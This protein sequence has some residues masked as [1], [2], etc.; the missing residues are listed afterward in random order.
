[1]EAWKSAG[2]TLFFL[3]PGWI[4]LPFWTQTWKFMKCFPDIVATAKRAKTG[5]E[6]FVATNG[7]IE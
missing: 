7:K 2:H 6:F 4:N 5:S 1:M 3:K